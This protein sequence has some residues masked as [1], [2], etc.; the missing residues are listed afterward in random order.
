[1]TSESLDIKSL[2]IEQL[3]KILAAAG[4]R[5]ITEE[6]IRSDVEAGVPTNA[7]GTINLI[8]YVAWLLRESSHGD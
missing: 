8:H 3:A 7:D 1:M 5:R 4:N 2:T 6:M